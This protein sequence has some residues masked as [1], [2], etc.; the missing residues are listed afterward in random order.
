MLVAG[1]CGAAVSI[2]DNATATKYSVIVHRIF[3]HSV[4]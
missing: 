3:H 4:C 2:V 1:G